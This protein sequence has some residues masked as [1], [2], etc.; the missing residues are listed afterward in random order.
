MFSK[1]KAMDAGKRPAFHEGHAAPLIQIL[2]WLFLVFS[3]LAVT[4]QF[5]TKKAMARQFVRADFV[6]LAALVLSVG[7]AAT[8]LSPAGQPIGNLQAG[9]S[10]DQIDG[11][12]K[13]LF[14]SEILSV[15]T[16]ITV[17][18]SLLVSLGSVTPVAGH[19]MMMR[20]TGVL[21]LLWGLSAVFLFA[22]QCPSPQRWDITNPKCMD[23]CAIRTYNAVMNI[24][25]DLALAIVPTLMVLP[26][27]ITSEKR[28]TLVTGFWSRIV[29]VFAS[30]AQ[31]GYIHSLPPQSDLLH[32]IW[33]IVVCGQVAQVASIMTTTI[34]FLKP[35]MMS[36]D[37]GLWSANHAG[38]ATTS[39]Y[40]SAVRT[41]HLSSY[42]KI[43]SQQS[44]DPSIVKGDK[45]IDIWV[46]K[47]IVVKREP[48]IEL[49]DIGGIGR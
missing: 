37:S 40:A 4:A 20:A 17:K 11:A 25:T 48:S 29:V 8:L 22:F 28:L 39:S 47:E 38:V 7:Q 46:R 35:F 30:A 3:I 12:W 2:A 18:G 27:Q 15:L 31:I 16:I 5:A 14:S 42:V 33:R 10:P 44:R 23:I 41:G 24:T 34:P 43:A 49:R 36:L 9:L 32:S 26:L 13:A 45:D 6:L 19:Q 1:R 21:T